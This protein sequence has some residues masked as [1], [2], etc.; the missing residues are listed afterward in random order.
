MAN[1]DE[2]ELPRVE[3]ADEGEDAGAPVLGSI[4]LADLLY[5]DD[6]RTL[7]AIIVGVSLE[8]GALLANK[9]SAKEAWDSIAAARISV[10][11]F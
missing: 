1:A 8:M 7:E 3:F 9:A 2:D 11:R 10:D 4:E 6:Q 5:H